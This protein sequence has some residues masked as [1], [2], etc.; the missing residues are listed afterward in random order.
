M[1]P[2]RHHAEWLSLVESSG[3]FLSMPVL[4]RV[5]P[6]GLDHRDSTRA[7]ALRENYEDWLERG[8][9]L[10]HV[11][12]AW[13]RH[14][15]ENLLE[16]PTDFIAE[17]QSIPAGLEASQPHFG[18]TLR[19]DFVLRRPLGSEGDTAPQLL[20]TTYS[21]IQDLEKPVNGKIWKA[22]PATRMTEL[23]HATGV[24]LGL[25]TNGEHWM[26]VYAPRGETCG[27]AS[28][29]A[30][31]WMQEPI[32]LRAFHS[33]L[34]LR[35]F[36]G[37]AAGET[38]AALY[39]ESAKDQQEV[40]DQLGR[41]VR[42]AVEM[43][44]AA[45][46][47]IDDDSGRTLLTGVPEKE[48]Y[49]AALTVMMRLV[50]LFCAEE[51]GLL[52][53]G[54]AL[55][56][57][58]YAVSTLRELLRERADQHGEE[59]LE[60]RHDA[61]SRLLATF[62]VVHGGVQHESM[63]LPAYGGSLFDPDRYPFLEGREKDT[64]W[65]ET[66]SQPL[67]VNNRVVLHL[68]EALQLLRVR[69][70][71]GGPTEAR[72]VSFRALD[73]EQ[74]G[75]VYEGLLDH[76]A[77]RADQLY[78]GLSGKHEPEIPLSKLEELF[79][80]DPA[81]FA[82]RESVSPGAGLLAAE[83]HEA[84]TLP[85][86]ARPVSYQNFIAPPAALI[87]FLKEETGRSAKA[88]ESALGYGTPKPRG[89][90]P[91]ATPEGQSKIQNLQS[92]IGNQSY[93][94]HS[95]LLA[96]GQDP[97]L[98][99][100]VAPFAGLLR[101]DDFGRLAVIRPGSVFVTA[102]TDRRSSGTHYTPKS[103]TEPIVKHT[104]DP[105]VYIGPA[106][107]IPEAEWKLKS[108]AEILSLKIC[109]LAMGSGAFLVQA[110]RYLADRLCEAWE[111]SEREMREASSF[112][113]QHSK[114]IILPNG[115]LS[116]GHA[117]ERLLPADPA[118]RVALARRYV[119][120]RC[121]YGVD[122]NPMAVEMAKLS[123]WLITLQKDRPFTFLDHALK[124]GDS[125]LG[126][127]DVKQIENFSLRPG[128]R[129]MTF[130][131]AN[132]FR[133]IEEAA[134]K[135]R[136]LEDLP[137]ND[138]SQIETKNRLHA[139][140]EAATAKVK[141]IADCLIA[142]ELLGLDG[143]AYEE[144]RADE[145][146][147]AQRLMQQDA[148]AGMKSEIK[149]L[150]TALAAHA[151]MQLGGRRPLHWPV[152][153]PEVF[154]RG[155]FDAFVGNPPFLA[156]TRLE[157]VFGAQYRSYL[158]A[159]IAKGR[160][161]VRGAADFC[162]Y[163]FLRISSLIR[164]TAHI[165]LIATNSI[166][167]GDS[168]VVCLQP[169]LDSDVEIYWAESSRPWP[170][171]AAL[172]VALIAF[173]PRGLGMPKLLNGEKVSFID[174]ALSPNDPARRDPMTLKECENRAFEGAKV[175]GDGFIITFEEAQSLIRANPKSV[176]VVKPYL[177]GD[178]INQNIA[179]RPSQWVINFRGFP[180]DK[181]QANEISARDFPDC[182]KIVEARVLPERLKLDDDTAWNR[183]L[184]AKWWQFGLWR[185]AIEAAMH[186]KERAF[187]TSKVTAHHVF[188]A[189]SREIVCADSALVVC[190]SEWKD[191]AIIQSSIHGA[192]AHRPGAMTLGTTLR[193]QPT[194][195][196]IT[197]PFPRI[198]EDTAY[199][200][201][202]LGKDY[203][204]RRTKAAE[205]FCVA[206]TDLYNLYHNPTEQSPDISQLRA[207]H[208]EMDRAVALAYGW[209]LLVDGQVVQP[210]ADGSYNP[211]PSSFAPLDLGHGF[212]ETKQGIRYTLSEPARREVLDRLL[213]LNHQ[214]HA[215]E[216]AAGLHEKKRKAKKSATPGAEQ[217]ASK[218]GR[219]AAIT[220]FAEPQEL[221]L[222]F[223][224]PVPAKPTGDARFAATLII[225]LLSEAQR[226][227]TSLRMSQLK[228]AFDFVTQ[229]TMMEG[230]APNASRGVVK[231][232]VAKWSSPIGPDWFIPTLKLLKGGT[233][234]AASSADDPPM[235]L[236]GKPLQP[237]SP[238]L[239]E[240][241]RLAV[242]VVGFAPPVPKEL[243]K[244]LVRERR[245]IF[246]TP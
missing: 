169:L 195:A 132:L 140:A 209:P 215:E 181:T 167:Q 60:R 222:D 127:S 213:A 84:H 245:S 184:K 69:V 145:A 185:P 38:L 50:F 190:L 182:L 133:Y 142:L 70:P 21:P 196:F 153:Y 122:I 210:P 109:D 176:E 244:S 37:V 92:S 240:G 30:D 87:E 134:G 35:R 73:I 57:Q 44:V 120:D 128:D 147:K 172:D 179:S 14:V 103:L 34:H 20:V 19:P 239:L 5:F 216:L 131:T 148:D 183:G 218:R 242:Q 173:G 77:R 65:R 101:T 241:I 221:G 159:E 66:P 228:Q 114:F 198:T 93:D 72:R 144:Q 136:A 22:S 88:L 94:H 124:C 236:V 163:F 204:E 174:S 2:A 162:C 10:L 112:D 180:L 161:G 121:L 108:P 85:F 12:T 51:R 61:W 8:R 106:E 151:K 45:F 212:H 194:F 205:G 165:S 11:H 67:P 234:K 99:R 211:P 71:G 197:F 17:G 23:L 154:E 115:S 119:A 202:R 207:L 178:D 15:L 102:G 32:T 63:R 160:R 137:S 13:I 223:G 157:P 36:F 47:Q 18:E 62:R 24:P 7:A 42:R 80:I 97:R 219:K 28:W 238:D 43:L 208:V 31:L 16:W 200:L 149:N 55:Y 229:P 26:I 3:P 56:D 237:D 107:G 187:V 25:V 76:T 206:M 27:F 168:R 4:L 40:T 130:A 79:G 68:L 125:L 227:K 96:C 129:Q 156:G 74:I 139:E 111:L 104:L 138:H 46:D 58:H 203:E 135:R 52:L 1:T 141:A 113:I 82:D 91:K 170:G 189:V 54:D 90:Q 191:F 164:H 81:N 89:R 116:T 233:V 53:L 126:V 75:H 171:I 98:A 78:I 29:Y 231:Q 48:V 232:W 155:G 224:P 117:T 235:V 226:Q 6:Q 9:P 225:G 220:V 193:Y 201:N 123:L 143:K 59:V 243:M 86:P 110:C 83:S 175:A 95:L 150:N 152:E 39:A 166:S 105:L 186:G 199:S 118:E 64:R 214:R 146:E 230:A 33:L 246:T 192:W 177:N 217:P 41:Q 158:V 100:R 188:V 49:D